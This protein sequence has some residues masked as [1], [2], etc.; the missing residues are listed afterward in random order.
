MRRSKRLLG[1]PVMDVS[2]GQVVGRVR[3]IILAPTEQRVA[4]FVI[5]GRFGKDKDVV[6]FA[7]VLS[8]GDDA[9][10][11]EG[12]AGI[13]KL[14]ELPELKKLLAL[15]TQLYGTSIMT[16]MGQHLG[17]VEEVL[18]ANDGRITHLVTS[19][20]ILQN[21]VK[22]IKVIP[23][24]YIKAVGKDAVIVAADTVVSHLAEMEAE[25]DAG[26]STELAPPPAESQP[27]EGIG[28][29]QRIFARARQDREAP[30]D[31]EEDES[32][33]APVAD[34][35]GELIPPEDDDA[36]Q[37]EKMWSGTL[38]RAKEV[39]DR[40][41]TKVIYLPRDAS[42]DPEQESSVS[43]K[44]SL[45][46]IWEQ[47]QQRLAQLKDEVDTKGTHFLLGKAVATKVVDRDGQVIIEAGEVITSDTI[48]AG[49][50]GNCLYQLA[51]S[52]AI[53]DVDERVRVLRE[54]YLSR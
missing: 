3:Q 44:L 4:G 38:A 50:E 11:V 39:N 8:M 5:G 19:G 47:W 15:S 1:L 6:Q 28:W 35:T 51:L 17:I 29:W 34:G 43:P 37:L 7:D 40:L 16:T 36:Q 12:S 52:A 25:P 2:I 41:N 32:S 27:T 48:A 31:P 30:S 26:Q 10:T 9:I 18:I 20:G 13:V 24:E 53:R 42:E 33:L 54:R 23:S 22:G 46:H 49:K 14:Q 45:S 21:F